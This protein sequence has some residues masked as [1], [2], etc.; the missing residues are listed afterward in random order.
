M[1]TL[2]QSDNVIYSG[3][4]GKA[5]TAARKAGLKK[6]KYR[7][8][9]TG[10]VQE[11]G[12]QYA[13]EID[14]PKQITINRI[15]LLPGMNIQKSYAPVSSSLGET[16]VNPQLE[17]V[18]DAN[19]KLT[20]VQAQRATDESGEVGG[21]WIMDDDGK[22]ISRIG[23]ALPGHQLEEGY[24]SNASAPVVGN[25]IPE[26]TVM[27]HRTHIKEGKNADG[28][29]KAA[30]YIR[31][32]GAKGTYNPVWQNQQ[33]GEYY[34][35]DPKSGEI[36]GSSSDENV[37]NNPMLWTRYHTGLNGDVSQAWDSFVNNRGA[38]RDAVDRQARENQE[39]RAPLHLVVD[40]QNNVIGVNGSLSQSQFDK[41]IKDARN[42][43]ASVASAVVNYANDRIISPIA[44]ISNPNYSWSDYFRT[45]DPRY[46]VQADAQNWGAGDVFNVQDPGARYALNMINAYS[47][48]PMVAGVEFNPGGF[49]VGKTNV[50]P[51]TVTYKTQAG[52]VQGGNTRTGTISEG[53][54]TGYRG[55]YGPNGRGI[56]GRMGTQYGWNT[57]NYSQRS[58]TVTAKG[59]EYQPV[60][61]RTPSNFSFDPQYTIYDPVWITGNRELGKTVA[62]VPY[63][64]EY[65]PGGYDDPYQEDVFTRGLGYANAHHNGKAASDGSRTKGNTQ[66]N[67]SS[68]NRSDDRSKGRRSRKTEQTENIQSVGKTNTSNKK[69][70]G[71]LRLVKRFN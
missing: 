23:K 35:V 40:G 62:E 9:K 37:I 21:A 68:G 12:T 5:F 41:G 55:G 31:V 26:V 44:A 43:A 49:K 8:P 53:M 11:Y 64:V 10:K 58:I 61:Y 63:S 2:I 16:R 36:I 42:N 48:A 56:G 4:F 19:G 39:M 51:V 54:G 32:K 30:G 15:D 22:L 67:Y 6:F 38:L 1:E 71:K 7:N 69:N 25:G 65:E 52:G 29:D 33:T 47:V 60:L 17:V 34:M 66:V 50:K 24:H 28:S 13:D 20:L 46:A 59:P 3:D 27:G 70:G 57:P 14:L 18:T 45:W